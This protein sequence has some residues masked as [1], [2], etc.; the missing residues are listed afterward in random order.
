[1]TPMHLVQILLPVY[2]NEGNELPQMEFR[3]VSSELSHRFG[4][5]T[6]FTRAP[7]EGVWK[8]PTTSRP[9]HDDI[10]VVEVMVGELDRD[11]WKD[12]RRDLERRFRQD[13]V[14]IRAQAMEQL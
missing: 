11:W 6:S 14:V 8:E 12:Y 13:E 10:V 2:D 4:G 5:V 1:M 3:R 9:T 7:A